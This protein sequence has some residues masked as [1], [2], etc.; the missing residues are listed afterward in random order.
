MSEGLQIIETVILSKYKANYE[1]LTS[2]RNIWK[3]E[4]TKC[5]LCAFNQGIVLQ[6]LTKKGL[7]YAKTIEVGE[8]SY[9]ICWNCL[10]EYQLVAKA[11]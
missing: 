3:N 10:E 8:V 5:C 6:G 1:G 9:F 2:Q 11:N 4:P 7:R